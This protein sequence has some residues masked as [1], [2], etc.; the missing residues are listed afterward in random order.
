[1]MHN[2]IADVRKGGDFLKSFEQ[3]NLVNNM[4]SFMYKF[5]KGRSPTF[6]RANCVHELFSKSCLLDYCLITRIPS[7]TN[8]ERG[9]SPTLS[10][11]SCVTVNLMQ[12]GFSEA[13]AFKT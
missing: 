6:S 12:I 8:H 5:Y 9:Q 1:M 13:I 10:R 7:R 4:R 2:F 11:A 3:S